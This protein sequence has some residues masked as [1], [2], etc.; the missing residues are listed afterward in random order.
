MEGIFLGKFVGIFDCKCGANFRRLSLVSVSAF[1]YAFASAISLNAKGMSATKE[2]ERQ[3]L[4]V[5][6]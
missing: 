5:E 2:V 3:V 1:I 6:G 4:A